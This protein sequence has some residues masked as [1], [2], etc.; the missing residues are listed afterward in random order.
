[1]ELGDTCTPRDETVCTEMCRDKVTPT[2]PVVWCYN[3]GEWN[4]GPG[5]LV[6]GGAKRA[7]VVVDTR[8]NMDT[9]ED[10]DLQ[11]G[12]SDIVTGDRTTA[13]GDDE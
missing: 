12:F 8:E 13:T 2:V 1:M 11:R 6:I 10:S 4:G 7:A 5:V 9:T 3:K